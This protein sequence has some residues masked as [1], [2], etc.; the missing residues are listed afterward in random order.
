[1]LEADSLADA[2]EAAEAVKLSE[3]FIANEIQVRHVSDQVVLILP[4]SVPAA[5]SRRSV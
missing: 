5:Q 1:M 4:L 3:E 2:A